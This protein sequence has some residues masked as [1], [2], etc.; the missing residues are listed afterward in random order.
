MIFNMSGGGAA[1]NFVVIPNPKP[2]TAKENTI[3]VDTDSITSWVFSAT[4]P[5]N[6]KAG[7]VWFSVAASSGVEFNALRKNGIHIY[8]VSAKQYIGG[9]WVS[10]T[11][12]IYQD[13]QWVEWML[14][15]YN[16]GVEYVDD[17]G[18]GW[19]CSGTH[20]KNADNIRVGATGG[21][22]YTGYAESPYLEMAG[23]NTVE[24]H[25]LEYQNSGTECH[26]YISIIDESNA[27]VIEQ[28]I[29]KG[30]GSDA[31]VTVLVDVSSVTAKCKV[32]ITAGHTRTGSGRAARVDFDIVRCY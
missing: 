32:R 22:A 7:M 18:N 25:V 1:L 21:S 28:D 27:T 5:D 19:F 26:S 12:K 13:G 11:A 15:L 8:P 9:E 24:L 4:A 20:T 16:K 31:N 30:T 10:V 2:E 17:N 14:Y 3:W 6:P 29:K 23:F